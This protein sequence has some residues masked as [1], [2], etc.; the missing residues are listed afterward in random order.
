MRMNRIVA[1]G[2]AVAAALGLVL[3]G[4]PSQA[5][6][7]LFGP[8]ACEPVKPCA[9]VKVCCPQPCAPVKMCAPVYCPQP[10]PPVKEC[11]PK[12]CCSRMVFRGEWP[13]E[14]V[15]VSGPVTVTTPATTPTPATKEDPT[16]APT[17][18]I[19]PTTKEVPKTEVPK[20]KPAE[21]PKSVPVVPAKPE[22]KV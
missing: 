14:S 3:V 7:G 2:I 15:K 5:T 11:C 6:A 22:K 20:T 21:S 12:P 17:K 10:C 8:G 13:C 19:T 18:A 9:P 1:L 16:K 4:V